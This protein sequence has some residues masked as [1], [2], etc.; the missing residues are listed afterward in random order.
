ML[1]F[2]TWVA[3][4]QRSYA[5]AMEAWQTSCP[6]L[7]VW[8]DAAIGGYIFLRQIDEEVVVTLTQRGRAVVDTAEGRCVAAD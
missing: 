2:L 3:A 7:S 5:D 8:E 6:R 4:K 1:E